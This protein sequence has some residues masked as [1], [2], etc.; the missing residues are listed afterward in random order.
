MG[1]AAGVKPMGERS[2]GVLVQELRK[3]A[4]LTQDDLGALMGL[5]EA[6]GRVTIAQWEN[7]NRTP[8][9]AQLP[10]LAACL[11]YWRIEGSGDLRREIVQRALA[12]A[13]DDPP[14][15]A[16]Q[17]SHTTDPDPTTTLVPTD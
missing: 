10:K 11:G 15:S 4:N 14:V 3:A 2:F 5:T 16:P 13:L 1:L 9:E 12:A 7:G 6:S 17:H 8:T